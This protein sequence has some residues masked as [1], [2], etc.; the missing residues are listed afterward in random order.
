MY[1]WKV[2]LTAIRHLTG[3]AARALVPKHLERRLDLAQALE[4][5]PPPRPFVPRESHLLLLARLGILDLRGDGADLVVE[6]ARLLRLLGARIALRRVP[7]LQLPRDVEVAPDVLRRLAHGLQAVPRLAVGLHDLW[8]EGLQAVAGGGHAFRADGQA[9]LD[10][11]HVD[12][13]RDVLHRLEARGAEPVDRR[14]GRGAGE[15][16]GEG[17]RADVVGSL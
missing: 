5:R 11:A 1:V 12:L 16:G 3:V 10:G 14:G 8:Y 6:R 4:R 7:V 15:A 17:C 13:V 2:G 9:A